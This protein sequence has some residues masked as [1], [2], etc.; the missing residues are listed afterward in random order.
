M[1]Q[2][3]LSASWKRSDGFEGRCSAQASFSEQAELVPAQSVEAEDSLDEWCR[4]HVHRE[5]Q[6]ADVECEPVE[7]SQPLQVG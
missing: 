5:G 1:A 3:S 6:C 2:D 4:F 7:Q